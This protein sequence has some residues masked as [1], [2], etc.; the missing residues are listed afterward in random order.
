MAGARSIALCPCLLAGVAAAQD[1]P[2]FPGYLEDV[3]G[4]LNED[5]RAALASVLSERSRFLDI[6]YQEP[7]AASENGGWNIKYDLRYAYLAGEGFNTSS[8]V[9]TLAALEAKLNIGGSYSFGSAANNEDLSSVMASLAYIGGWFGAV[10]YANSESPPQT[11]AY[12]QCKGELEVP[13][14]GDENAIEA[15]ERASRRCISQAA[16]D[17]LFQA[18]GP[19]YA[20]EIGLQAGLEGNQD[21]SDTHDVYGVSGVVSARH[22][23]SLR[24][25]L[26][27]VDAADNEL[28]GRLTSDDNYDRITLE[29][30]YQYSMQVVKDLPVTLSLG[31]RN[32]RELSAPLEIEQ[33]DLDEFD[34]WSV[35]LRVPARMFRFIESEDYSL[36]VRY[37]DGQLPFDRDADSAFELGFSSNI[38]LLAKLFE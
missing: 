3:R 25:E 7:D 18:S 12:Q 5:A 1:A 23:P 15:Y 4:L 28:R 29:I 24:L 17:G 37:T 27:R 36:Y 14:P 11:L 21:Y 32:F 26:E 19:A 9:A 34:H 6:N 22:W 30:G 16:V 8:G 31:Y 20:Y 2:P 10:P 33:A 13:R 38:A 35:S